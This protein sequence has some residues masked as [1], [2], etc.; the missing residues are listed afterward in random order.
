MGMDS[1]ELMMRFEKEFKID[2][3]DP[4]AE[5]MAVVGDVITWIY[6]NIDIATPDKHLYDD[7]ARRL[8]EGLKTIGIVETIAPHTTL[9]NIIPKETLPA[10]WYSL[11][12]NSGLMLPELFKQD[13]PTYKKKRIRLFKPPKYPSPLDLEFKRLVECTGALEYQKFV[14]F[15]HITSL[16]EVTIAV[17]GITY[18]Q[19]GVDIQEAHWD[20]YFTNDLGID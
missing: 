1:V 11:S 2:I 4:A 6:H 5:Y 13:L 19:S 8:I 18:E 16:F 3:P 17:M 15:D 10:S 7:L 12:E 14:D 9:R 20:A